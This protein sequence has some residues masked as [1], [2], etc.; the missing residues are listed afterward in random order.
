MVGSVGGGV[1]AG[2]DEGNDRMGP[3]E[4]VGAGAV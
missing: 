1:V 3:A 4:R 2:T